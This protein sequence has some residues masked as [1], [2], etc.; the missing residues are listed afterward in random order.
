MF[1]SKSLQEL[2]H[3][4]FFLLIQLLF[5]VR[6]QDIMHHLWIRFYQLQLSLDQLV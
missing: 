5:P 3:S 4:I 1:L 6:I 2:L